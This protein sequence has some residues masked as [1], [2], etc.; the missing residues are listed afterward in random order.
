MSLEK[1]S[2]D[3]MIVGGAALLAVISL[4]FFP[5]FSFSANIAGVHVYSFTTSGT[6]SPDGWLGVLAMLCALAVAV[7]LAVERFSP[8]TVVPSIQDS[9]EMTRFVLA[10]AAAAFVA[11][12]FILH[13]HFSYFGWGFYF[14]VVVVGVMLYMTMKARAAT[15]TVPPVTTV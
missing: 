1:L 7:D 8:G 12:K 13:I 2:R 5:W 6:G 9:R 10:A 14:T 3:D 4:L 15:A 11:L